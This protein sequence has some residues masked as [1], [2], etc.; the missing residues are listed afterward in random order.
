MTTPTTTDPTRIRQL[1]AAGKTVQQVSD[2]TSL[3][4]TAVLAVIKNTRGWL[5]DTTR[6]T[7]FRSGDTEPATEKPHPAPLGKAPVAELLTGAVDLDDKTVQ[8]ELRKTTDQIARLREAV[9]TA[10]ERAA[11]A[12][13]VAVLERRLAEAKARLK[14]TSPRRTTTTGSGGGEPT[15]RDIRAWAKEN[16]VACNAK[17]HVPAH[18]RA[19][20]D[21]AHG[22]GQ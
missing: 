18:V 13:E 4:R 22:A 15:A 21:A 8:R 11:A 17:G 16:N 7:I 5:H 2:L 20:Y 14:A 3:P 6:D 10:E 12:R 19:Q 1:L 9:T